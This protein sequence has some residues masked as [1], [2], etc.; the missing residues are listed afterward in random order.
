[1]KSPKCSSSLRLLIVQNK[2]TMSF[3]KPTGCGSIHWN[4]ANQEICEKN[5][6]EVF[7]FS[8]YDL[9][10]RSLYFKLKSKC[11]VQWSLSLYQDW[12]QSV[13]VPLKL[14]VKLF[15]QN[16]TRRVLTLNMD[17]T[18]WNEHRSMTTTNLTSI[19][20]SLQMDKQSC[21]IIAAG[22]VF[23]HLESMSRSLTLVSKSRVQ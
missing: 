14:N 16:H 5:N 23:L 20:N 10:W 21:E 1:M 17:W 22:V 2:F 7:A 11:R 9:E 6:A 18:I 15:G 4:Q 19:L 3:N 13:N 8:N 12:K